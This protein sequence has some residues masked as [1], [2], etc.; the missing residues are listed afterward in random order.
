MANLSS[1]NLDPELYDDPLT[2]RF[3]R[4]ANRHLAFGSGIHRCLRCASSPTSSS[5]GRRNADRSTVGFVRFV[6]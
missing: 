4:D 5:S 3:D 2:V 6:T 1:A